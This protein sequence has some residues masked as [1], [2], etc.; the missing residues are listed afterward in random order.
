MRTL[1]QKTSNDNSDDFEISVLETVKRSF[2]VDDCLKSVS[3][4]EKGMTMAIDLTKLLARRGFRLT[5]WVSNS[6]KVLESIPE[7]ERTGSVRNLNFDQPAE[8][9]A[10]AMN[11]NIVTD[12]FEFKV[13][14]YSF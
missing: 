5:K 1:L 12:R 7:S 4:D 9:R 2:Y 10:L 11:W 3:N 14:S 8:E 13:A 6:T